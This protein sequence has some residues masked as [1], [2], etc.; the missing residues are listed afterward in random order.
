MK[1]EKIF[2]ICKKLKK[3]MGELN[4]THQST[5]IIRMWEDDD[6]DVE[7]RCGVGEN[8]HILRYQ[9]SKNKIEYI[10]DKFLSNAVK[11]DEY[12]NKYYVPNELIKYMNK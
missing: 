11:V 9:M 6:F 12:G 4:P 8:V 5:T 3:Q 7:C 10:L 1:N 2:D